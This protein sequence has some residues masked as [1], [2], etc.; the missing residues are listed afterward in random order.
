MTETYMVIVR[1][2]GNTNFRHVLVKQAK[3]ENHA[4]LA[5]YFIIFSPHDMPSKHDVYVH[6]GGFVFGG[7]FKIDH[8]VN[9]SIYVEP[10]W[11]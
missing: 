8:I 3:S 6:T 1:V 2:A 9:A 5:A 4:R 7:P 11:E 10:E